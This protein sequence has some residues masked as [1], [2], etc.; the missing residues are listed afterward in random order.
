MAS[1]F[2]KLQ[3]K[4]EDE[5]DK[6]SISE[7]SVRSLEIKET[8]PLVPVSGS[9]DLTDGRHWGLSKTKSR[10]LRSGR[11]GSEHWWCVREALLA[12]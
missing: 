1:A 11:T 4:A 12:G 5:E 8:K 9:Y 6:A 3:A 10:T 2:K 7:E